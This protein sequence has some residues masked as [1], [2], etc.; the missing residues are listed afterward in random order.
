[1]SLKKINT[2]RFHSDKQQSNNSA[3]ALLEFC[4]ANKQL[5]GKM[6]N[7]AKQLAVVVGFRTQLKQGV[8]L[9][10]NQKSYLESIYEKV[11]EVAGFDSCKTKHDLNRRK[12]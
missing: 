8:S 2:T 11:W 10:P 7:G 3:K 1:M 9:T 6:K 12:N 5:F 4:I